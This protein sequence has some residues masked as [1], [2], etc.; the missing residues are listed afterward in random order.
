MGTI[1]FGISGGSQI[2][3][4]SAKINSFVRTSDTTATLSVTV[5]YSTSNN[6]NTDHA[7]YCK[8][9]SDGLTFECTSGKLD[10]Y[11]KSGSYFEY[12]GYVY[13]GYQSGSYYDNGQ[14]NGE[15]TYLTNDF[16]YRIKNPYTSTSS[17]THT[18][19]FNV[20]GI[21]KEASTPQIIFNFC[22]VYGR[23]NSTYTIIDTKK[24][25]D[26]GIITLSTHTISAVRYTATFDANGGTAPNPSTITKDYNTNWGTLPT[27]TRTGYQ[28]DGW[29]TAKSGGTKVTSTTK[30]DT[31]RT[32]Y[33]HWTEY[34]LT[35][36]YYSNG[37]TNYSGTSALPSGV[38]VNG[39]NVCVCTQ[40]VGYDDSLPYGLNN[41]SQANSTLT[42]TRTGYTPTYK[43][44]TSTS[45][46]TTIREDTSNETGQSIAQKL[47]KD[48]S[49]GNASVNL[50]AQWENLPAE[51]NKTL[52]LSIKTTNG[53]KSGIPHIKVDG[54]FKQVKS[55]HIKT[56][57]IWK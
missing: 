3:T 38:T 7:I 46:G 12:P 29:Y 44:G 6:A 8:I 14:T 34:K 2:I 22:T 39:G 5:G 1:Q 9:S 24:N 43:W 45:G 40:I 27:T 30:A 48:L 17:D 26:D 23:A 49:S 11:R 53:Y 52:S 37:A 16:G 20:S 33:A 35:I 50:Y 42:M 36:K 10:N 4:P 55:I 15:Y 51:N 25:S 18:F 41:Y 56:N 19:T 54:V 31:S 28:F 47:G 32:L 13:P 21:S 57:G